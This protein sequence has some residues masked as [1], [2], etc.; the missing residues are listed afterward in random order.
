MAIINDFPQTIYVRDISE[1]Q[2]GD[3][4]VIKKQFKLTSNNEVVKRL[5]SEF[6]K[7]QSDRNDLINMNK[8]L[9]AE[10]TEMEEKLDLLKETFLMLK[11]L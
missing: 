4:T 9:L 5:F 6:L 1:Q 11:N 8:T 7:V 10:K 2:A 3:Y